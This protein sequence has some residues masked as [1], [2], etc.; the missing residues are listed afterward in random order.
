MEV[1]IIK[2]DTPREF[3]R[4]INEL[5]A[6]GW[7]CISHTFTLPSGTYTAILERRLEATYPV[8]YLK[9]VS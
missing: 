8:D 1:K 5:Y 6:D 9:L 7:R 3:E 2:A 4:R